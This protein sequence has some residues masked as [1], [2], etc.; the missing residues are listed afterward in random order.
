MKQKIKEIWFSNIKGDVLSGIVVS[1]ALIPEAI[2]FSI[3]AGVSPMVG[4]YASVCMAIMISFAGGRPGMISAATG[5]MALVM[6]GLVKE[7]G[8]EYMF[9]ATILTGII[10]I[11]LSMMKVGK[12]IKFVPKSVM[13]GFVNSLAIL[14]FMAQIP[15]FYGESWQMYAMVL[16]GLVII[17]GFPK[18]TNS[19][20]SPLVAIIAVSIVSILTN[21]DVRTVGDMGTISSGLPEFSFPKIVLDVNSIIVLL[22]Y[23]LSLAFVGLIESLLTSQIVDEMTETTSDKNR[24]CFGQ[25]ISNIVVGLFG[26]M[27]SCAMI[28]QS[29]INIKSG[30]RKRLSTLV[31]G[32][33]LMI[34]IIALNKVVVRIPLAA[35][36]AVM[37]MVSIGTFNWASVSIKKIKTAPKGDIFTMIV[38]VVVVVFTHNLAL[39]VFLGTIMSALIFAIKISQIHVISDVNNNKKIYE[40]TGQLFF[41]SAANFLNQFDFDDNFKYVEVDLSRVHVW[42]ESAVEAI[43]KLVLRYRKNDVNV[44]LI[45]LNEHS[46]I[47]VEKLGVFNKLNVCEE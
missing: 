33:F 37:I 2:G 12:L 1:L 28:G 22:K 40:V 10:Q 13:L 20:P 45:G 26:G 4:L 35:L 36:V 38:T 39:G 24:E 11:L 17:Y 46:N 27:A 44:K 19:I 43:D 3:I 34:L 42:D 5:A 25:G 47:L 6:A 9:A 15:S 32:V 16:G 41:A 18:I 23:S 31:S 8:V 14:I 30:G 7:Y 21:S 29:V